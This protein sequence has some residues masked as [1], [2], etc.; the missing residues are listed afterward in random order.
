MFLISNSIAGNRRQSHAPA[1]FEYSE[2]SICTKGKGTKK[3]KEKQKSDES[4]DHHHSFSIVSDGFI[5]ERIYKKKGTEYE[6]W[7]QFTYPRRRITKSKREKILNDHNKNLRTTRYTQPRI[8]RR[9][10][11][12]RIRYKDNGISIRSRVWVCASASSRSRRMPERKKITL[13]NIFKKNTYRI[14][15]D[16]SQRKHFI[17]MVFS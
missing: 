17:I 14:W 1:L 5:D 13:W 11:M 12:R 16:E 15:E 2:S 8:N 6:I 10:P 9:R 7:F 3:A 4:D